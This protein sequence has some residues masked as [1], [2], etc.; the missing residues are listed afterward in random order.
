MQLT[1]KNRK[2][3]LLSIV[4]LIIV[5]ILVAKFMGKSQDE[6]F[7]N[8]DNLYATTYSLVSEQKYSEATPFISELLQAQPSSEAV[9][10][11]GSIVYANNGDYKQAAIL[12]QKAMDL[13]PYNVENPMFMLQFGEVLI[14][15]ERYE[16]AKTVL[17]R[18]QES[19][20]A[21]QEYPT[22]QQRVQELLAYIETI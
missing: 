10:Y 2:Y 22:Y 20:W 16:D 11:L 14:F 12:M 5:G 9:N 3:I 13:N 15:S 8:E 17:T 6:Q 18:C 21:P 19:G 1:E 7:S 4:C